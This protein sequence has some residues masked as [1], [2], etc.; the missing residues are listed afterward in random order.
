MTDFN[1][2]IQNQPAATPQTSHEAD[3]VSD[4]ESIGV[5]WRI[6]LM[7]ATLFG[8]SVFVY[9][10]LKFGYTNYLEARADTLDQNMNSL[11]TEVSEE[12]QERLI[13]FYSQLVNLSKVLDRHV[14]SG[15][16][17]SFLERNT[18]GTV[19][20]T[21]VEFSEESILTLDGFATTPEMVTNQ[22]ASLEKT[23]AVQKVIL[24][25]LTTTKLGS[26]FS[27]SVALDPVYFKEPR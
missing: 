16:L 2:K 6:L 9:F 8:L 1:Q 17:F 25:E 3:A 13:N 14:F 24:N 11:A 18:L 10:G 15:N 5:P 19:Y 4:S 7:S 27:L 23:P 22:I 12:D 20:F 21:R 26:G